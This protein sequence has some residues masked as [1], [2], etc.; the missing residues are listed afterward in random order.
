MSK[1]KLQTAHI[2]LG[3]GDLIILAM[4]TAAGFAT[5]RELDTAPLQRILA[6]FLPLLAAWLAILPFSRVY[7]LE[8]ASQARS[9][10]RPFW[11]MVLCV[12]FAMWLRSAWLKTTVIPL[13][14]LVMAAVS[15][16]AILAWRAAFVWLGRKR[17][18]LW[19][20]SS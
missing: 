11:A 10:W 17:T 9:L 2:L 14:V 4:V 3:I 5:H 19:T 8:L 16:L 6:V 13:F 1:F 15:A 12:P 20:K 7:D 18:G